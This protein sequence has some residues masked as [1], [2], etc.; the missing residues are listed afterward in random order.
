MPIDLGPILRFET[1]LI[2][3]RREWYRLRMALGIVLLGL[4]AM[5]HWA[6]GINVQQGDS[7]L[8]SQRFCRN[9]HERLIGLHFVAALLIA[10]I[11]AA[12]AFSRERIRHDDADAL[13]TNL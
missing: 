5:Y 7:P 4:L 13:V 3:G 2:A 12:D 11:A 8:R 10:P 6:F 1:R 9:S